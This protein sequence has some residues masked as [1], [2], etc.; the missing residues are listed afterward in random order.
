MG[1]QAVVEES[2]VVELGAEHGTALGDEMRPRLL[3]SIEG[4]GLRLDG[5]FLW[6]MRHNRSQFYCLGPSRRNEAENPLLH[7]QGGILSVAK[8]GGRREPRRFE[9]S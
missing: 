1:P 4:I 7:V 3:E 5:G 2:L 6:M 9:R 8:I